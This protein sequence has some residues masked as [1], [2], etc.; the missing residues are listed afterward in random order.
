MVRFAEGPER[1]GAEWWRGDIDE[2]RSHLVA[3]PPPDAC[4]ADARARH[5]DL[6]ALF[7]AK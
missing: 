2:V 6:C 5:A 4:R 7:A 3:T 1:I